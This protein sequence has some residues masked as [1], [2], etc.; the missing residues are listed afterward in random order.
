MLA[1]LADLAEKRDKAEAHRRRIESIAREAAQ[2]AADAQG[3]AVRIAP[4]LAPSP[5][6]TIAA[7]LSVRLKDARAAHAARTGSSSSNASNGTTEDASKTVLEMRGRLARSAAKPAARRRTTSPP[8]NSARPVAGRSNWRRAE[9]DQQIKRLALPEPL[10]AFRAEAEAA[11]PDDLARQIAGLDE[12][13]G[14]AGS[15]E[16]GVRS[17]H[18]PRGDHPRL[19]GR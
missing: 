10:D 1:R 9:L 11:D 16:S 14:G 6:E 5:P 4:D 19:H 13:I 15:R 8:S 7:E 17:G 12:T 2:F 18:R 3:L